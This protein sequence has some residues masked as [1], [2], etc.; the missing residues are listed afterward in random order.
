MGE[1]IARTML[2]WWKLLIKLSLLHLVAVYIITCTSISLYFRRD[3]PVISAVGNTTL[4]LKWHIYAIC[5]NLSSNR[6]ALCAFVQRG[7]LC[8]GLA[9][10]N[11]CLS[12]PYCN[13]CAGLRGFEFVAP[14]KWIQ[15]HGGRW[16]IVKL[17]NIHLLGWCQKI[18]RIWFWFWKLHASK[19][20]EK[21]NWKK[22]LTI[23][24]FLSSG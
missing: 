1:I 11:I 3:W 10:Q 9:F 12:L 13:Y 17:C 14:F 21:L 16:R 19:R 24:L 2:S 6:R 18:L 20:N 23:T 5:W 15:V 4:I 7:M 8:S 22:L